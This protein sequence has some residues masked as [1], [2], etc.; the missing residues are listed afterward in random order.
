MKTNKVVLSTMAGLCTLLLAGAP[1]S[2]Q[3]AFQDT[4]GHW[5]QAAIDRM[6]GYQIVNGFGGQFRP[7]DTIT[8][9]E[10]AVVLDHV[11]RYQN[12][13]DN[14]FSD[15]GQAFYTDAILKAGRAG[16]L[17]GAD[18]K[19]RPNDAISREEAVV[20]MARAFDI[21]TINVEAI[22]VPD[23]GGIAGWAADTVSAFI[24]KGY[25]SG[26]EPFRPKE[27]I[28]RAETVA[29]L[30][31][32]LTGY[33]PNAGS[34]SES[35]DGTVVVNTQ[36]VS[37]KDMTIAGDLILSEGVQDGD[38]TLENVVVKGR[39]LIRGG[40]A[41]SIHVAGKSVLGTVVMERD[42]AAVRLSVDGK[43]AKVEHVKVGEKAAEAIVAGDVSSVTVA[44]SSKL[45][46]Q[47]AKIGTV[48]VT[49]PD[50]AVTLSGSSQI[51][52]VEVAQD[53]KNTQLSVDKGAV[54]Q[55]MDIKAEG[56]DISGDGKVSTVKANAD[57][58]SVDTKGT[59]V[60]AA[61]GTTG[62]TAGG[63][64]VPSGSS[65]N[66]TPSKNNS[67]SSGSSSSNNNRPSKPNRPSAP[68]KLE[69]ER[70][71][72]VKNGLVRVT[73]NRATDT[74]LRQDQFSII[75][76]GGG[77]DMTI[78][79]VKTTDN[80]VYDLSTAYYNDNTYQLG[81]LLDDQTLLTYDFVSKYD[82][83]ELTSTEA[84]R[85]AADEATFSYVS[86][87]SGTFYWILQEKPSTR[88][89]R[90]ANGEPTAEEV[91]A[92]GNQQEM[93]LHSNT[94]TLTGLKPDTAYSM[95]YVAK[96]IDE[97]V[98]PVKLVEIAGTPAEKPEAS[99]VQ[100]TSAEAHKIPGAEM[101]GELVYFEVR[102]DKPTGQTLTVDQ[103]EFT[104]PAQGTMKLKR[105]ETDDNQNYK[106]YMK[107]GYMPQ[108]NNHF[109]CTITFADGKDTHRFFV[110][111]TAP[112]FT[113]VKIT[114]T[115]KNTAQVNFKS[116][117]AG[118]VYWKVMKGSDF[119]AGDSKPKDPN[120]VVSDGQKKDITE[121]TQYFD[122]EIPAEVVDEKKLYF[123]FVTE[124]E[125]GN[126]GTFD[127]YEIPETVVAPEPE[128][129]QGEYEIVNITGE[130]QDRGGMYGTGHELTIT[131]NKNETG[132]GLFGNTDI[133]I[134]G[135]G[136][137]I[138]GYQKISVACSS[139]KPEDHIVS[140]INTSL[141]PG[142]YTVEITLDK[143]KITK[144]IQVADDGKGTV[145][146][147]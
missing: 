61:K 43:D 50:A 118:Q 19:V 136:Q 24:E 41:N 104:C 55:T 16:V 72:S 146:L 122:F 13:A 129:E 111:F 37:L 38:V 144:N 97:K 26:T 54:V 7:D 76:T 67:S 3:A 62:I 64:K 92:S 47:D 130:I 56:A 147:V 15:L 133:R 28:T 18:G 117:E 22:H 75:C 102:L 125:K 95:Y 113:A 8:R 79:N 101:T 138:S 80:R 123:C 14:Y 114:R 141:K 139:D 63:Q 23:A 91:M 82:C 108:D 121:G 86:D 31:H 1:S 106:V 134:T 96:G 34:F 74:A 12:R 131:M 39:V 53:A 112:N 124:D 10:M 25:V 9:G 88:F 99:D 89:R 128:P 52:N 73:L 142:E 132:F 83:P 29:I 44:G 110:D 20:M 58:I 81:I 48:R 105:V 135:N 5:A 107:D 94:V 100:I 119:G 98:T 85:T 49:A 17:Q 71:E 40:G 11:M 66:S 70:V 32:I 6:Q 51:K 109:T 126:Q 27:P 87:T 127:Y 103:F 57:D 145:T 115:E 30:N 120:L 59:V 116:S 35:A 2:A 93:K 68:D 69:I 65:I 45:T 143:G 78:V 140:L 42:G 90:A 36:D 4:N 60:K 77:S 46:A 33:Y 21:E 84:V 137:T